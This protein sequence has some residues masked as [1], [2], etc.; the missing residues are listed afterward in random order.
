MDAN[1]SY[2]ES[3]SMG[4][5]I[6]SREVG[7]NALS[8]WFDNELP[9]DTFL[10]F[11]SPT[12]WNY[13]PGSASFEGFPTFHEGSK[14]ANHAVEGCAPE[15]PISAG[16]LPDPNEVSKVTQ[17]PDTSIDPCFEIAK[18]K[19]AYHPSTFQQRL[20]G[21]EGQ[22]HKLS[23]GQSPMNQ[24]CGTAPTPQGKRTITIDGREHEDWVNHDSPRFPDF[25]RPALGEHSNY[26]QFGRSHSSFNLNINSRKE[27]QIPRN[28]PDGLWNSPSSFYMGYDGKYYS[29]RLSATQQPPPMLFRTSSM[30]PVDNPQAYVGAPQHGLQLNP[31][32]N[33]TD[34]PLPTSLIPGQLP[35]KHHLAA[36]SQKPIHEKSQYPQIT[37]KRPVPVYPEPPQV[38]AVIPAQELPKSPSPSHSR[39]VVLRGTSRRS[40]NLAVDTA[41]AQSIELKESI[42]SLTQGTPLTSKGNLERADFTLPKISKDEAA[43]ADGGLYFHTMEEVRKFMN[44]HIPTTPSDPTFPACVKQMFPYV[45]QLVASMIDMSQATDNARLLESWRNQLHEARLIEATCWNLVERAIQ[46]HRQGAPLA[47]RNKSV[48]G[49]GVYT[50]FADH[51]AKM[52]QGMRIHKTICSHL[53]RANYMDGFVDNPSSSADRVDNNRKVNA[54]KKDTIEIGRQTRMQLEQ[55]QNGDFTASNSG[56]YDQDYAEAGPSGHGSKRHQAGQ[57]PEPKKTRPIR[58]ASGYNADRSQAVP[59]IEGYTTFNSIQGALQDSN[60]GG[61][62]NTGVNRTELTLLPSMLDHSGELISPG[63]LEAQRQLA[64]EERFEDMQKQ[65]SEFNKLHKQLKK[66]KKR[67]SHSDDSDDDYDGGERKKSRK[68]RKHQKSRD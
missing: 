12:E 45:K 22:N 40:P 53:L 16:K 17:A 24:Q 26:P 19:T 11:P 51:V 50:N 34:S 39:R 2:V 35:R 15:T 59:S 56:N 64:E 38:Y 58:N 46:A 52:C 28:N 18:N 31:P 48:K 9:A 23:N 60:I 14:S 30:Y 41:I 10:D 20:H 42:T 8:H 62:N 68:S 57:L 61:S 33:F 54:K 37:V 29:N 36:Y 49:R 25:A 3:D 1:Y 13:L 21:N 7:S 44:P 6:D 4:N 65:I 67:R 55:T 5:Q 66:S 32:R 63:T 43:E 27:L 47:P